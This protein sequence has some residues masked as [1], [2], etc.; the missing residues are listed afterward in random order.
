MTKGRRK[1]QKAKAPKA[2]LSPKKGQK[3]RDGIWKR[4]GKPVCGRS[5]GR[6]LM[7]VLYFNVGG[8]ATRVIS[9]LHLDKEQT[10]SG[11]ARRRLD[12][13]SNSLLDGKTAWNKG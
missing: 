8:A 11:G 7:P 2:V 13:L 1:T 10:A 5:F 6:F 9:V 12:R 4:G 3:G